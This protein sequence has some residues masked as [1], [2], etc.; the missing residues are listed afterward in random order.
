[1]SEESRISF[2]LERLG[3]PP[4]FDAEGF[5]ARAPWRFAKTMADQPHEYTQRK[6]NPRDDFEAMVVHI[7]EHGYRERYG[8]NY[9]KYLNVGEWRYW[10][11]GWPV[12]V[13]IIINRT[14]ID[15]AGVPN[16]TTARRSRKSA[17]YSSCPNM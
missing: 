17:T 14:R 1:M 2:D 8:R 15:T 16:H 10:T 5:I 6:D 12:T 7:R 3:L 11:M 4:A 9:Y 13:T